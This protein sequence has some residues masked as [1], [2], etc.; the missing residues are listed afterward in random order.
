MATA[1]MSSPTGVHRDI[2]YATVQI[3]PSGMQLRKALLF[4]RR[5]CLVVVG[6]LCTDMVTM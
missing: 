2:S 1:G 4:R 6:G 5:Q 3:C